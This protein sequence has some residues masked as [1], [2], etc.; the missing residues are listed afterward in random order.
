[1]KNT[2]SGY[3]F[4]N[5]EKQPVMQNGHTQGGCPGSRMIHFDRPETKS[6]INVSQDQPSQLR[7]WPVQ[8]YLLSPQAPYLQEA[9]VLLAADCVAFAMGNFHSKY[10]AGKGLAIA[11][12]KLDHGKEIYINKLAS[13]IDDAKIN[14]LTVMKMQVP[15]CS[16]LLHIAKTAAEQASRK[17]PIKSITVDLQGEAIKEEWV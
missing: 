4:E 14:T 11:C 3:T 6:G 10:L 15:C 1:M 7:Q 9:D 13:M 16:G 2:S 5:T 8:L 17:V 12:P